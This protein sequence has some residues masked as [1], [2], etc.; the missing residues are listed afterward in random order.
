MPVIGVSIN[1]IDGERLKAIDMPLGVKSN[2]NIKDVRELDMPAFN[3]KGLNIKFDFTV[4]YENEQ[5]V[6]YGNIIIGGEVLYIS[7]DKQDAII[8]E[9]KKTKKLGKDVNIEILNSIL[10]KCL[11]KSISITDDLQLPP[12][13]TLPYATSKTPATPP[14]K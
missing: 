12:P 7:P 11:V 8:E 14:K 13:I 5:N 1:K 4:Q 10:R 6:K 2:T 9:W 3:R